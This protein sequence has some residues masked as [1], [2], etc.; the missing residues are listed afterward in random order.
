M[1]MRKYKEGDLEKVQEG[2]ALLQRARDLFREAGVVR[3]TVRVRKALTSAQGA[4]RH[5]SRLQ[6]L[7]SLSPLPETG[8]TSST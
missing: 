8:R 1:K 4:E 7:N 2:I 6:F 3:T 5:V